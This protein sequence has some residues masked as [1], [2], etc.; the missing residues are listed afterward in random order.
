MRRFLPVL[1]PAALG[2]ALLP[3]PDRAVDRA[4]LRTTYDGPDARQDWSVTDETDVDSYG[5]YRRTA[6]TGYQLVRSLPAA[7]LRHYRCFDPGAFRRAG[8]APLTCRL[9]IRRLGPDQNQFTLLAGT[10]GP[11]KRS[12]GTI[13]EMFR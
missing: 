8:G 1:L 6:A 3:G 13:K 4:H 9:V 10:L 12:W 7:G 2:L 11:M 5:L